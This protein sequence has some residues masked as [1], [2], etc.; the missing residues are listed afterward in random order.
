VPSSLVIVN[1]HASRVRD[2]EVR[3]SLEATLV[4]TLGQRDGAEP[5][6]AETSSPEEVGPL[7]A[8][9]VEAGVPLVVGVGGDGTQRDIAAVLAG[10]Q[11]PLGIV[12][13][14]TGNQIAAVLGIPRQPKQAVAALADARARTIDLGQA[15][16]EDADGAT[17][18]STFIIGCGVGFDAELMATTPAQLK[19]RLGAAAYF[20]QGARL[21]LR[22]SA[23]P[24]RVTVDERTVEA[25]ITAAL[26]GNMGELVPGRLGLRL[27]L[28]PA[29]G[30]LDLIL[31]GAGNTLGAFRGLLDQVRRTEIGVGDGS[32]RLRGRSI[33][34]E[35]TQP[36]AL[37]IDGD[38][39]G[40][41]R[42]LSATVHPAALQVLAPTV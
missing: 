21:A 32:I 39:V 15:T 4:E 11:V 18:S 30:L 31:V 20:V 38:H 6:V 7:A 17:I 36:M 41:G 34:I 37:E 9:A 1:P 3:R 19:Q 40:A 23:T 5:T 42:R 25:P 2:P 8:G 35:P 26:I 33:S 28:D 16:V 24:G 14:G 22:L 12:P 10:T 29:D 27:P 13:A